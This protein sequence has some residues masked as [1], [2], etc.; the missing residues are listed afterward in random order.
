MTDT[1]RPELTHVGIYV[2]NLAR[3][4]RFYTEIMKLHISDRGHGFSMPINI[5][6]LTADPTKHHQFVLAEGRPADAPSSINQ[7]S[8][9]VGSLDELR[10]MYQRVQAEGVDRLR[11]INH[12][13]AWSVYFEDPEGNTIEIYL[14]T[15]WY[16]SQ[17][18]GDVLDL[19]LSDESIFKLTEEMCRKDAHFMPVGEWQNKMRSELGLP[20]S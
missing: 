20:S 19:S 17:P 11:A 8:F 10:T 15:P 5:V 7:A 13:N 14:D 2:I 4:T 9:K 6:F 18:H 16:V 1:L 12:G 3:M